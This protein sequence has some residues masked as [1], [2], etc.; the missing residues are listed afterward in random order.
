MPSVEAPQRQTGCDHQRGGILGQRM[1]VHLR[2]QGHLRQRVGDHGRHAQLFLDHFR[3]AAEHGAAAGQHDVVNAVELAAC[4]EELQ[5]A[6]DLLDR[7]FLE[8]L[9][10]FHLVAFR[11]PALALGQAGLLVAQA[12]TAH[13]LVGQLLATEH[14]FAAVQAAAAAQDIE[15][16]HGGADVHERDH[17]V[18]GHRQLAGDQGVGVLD[19]EGLHVHHL[20]LQ[21]TQFQGRLAQFHV[22]RTRRGQQYLDHLRVVRDRPDH[23]EVQ[24]HFL[25]RVRNVV[26][27]FQLDLGFHV[28]LVELGRHR[29]HLGDHRRTGNG[30]SGQLGLAPRAVHRAADG[31]TYGL[32]FHDVL[33]HHR[34]RR[35]RFHSVVFHAK[36][37][38]TAGQLQKLYRSRTDVDAYKRR[39]T[40]WDEPH[41]FSPADGHLDARPAPEH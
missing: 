11:Q 37:V 5:Q 32:H 13:D 40:F 26:D 6:A 36:T 3:Q 25:D 18:D 41:G 29:D 31:L 19:R 12:V 9:Q 8:R 35:K 14:L 23:L 1:C 7:G 15:R 16:G 10:H 28:V 30:G 17:A 22:L 39:L 21:A 33:F 4:I 38:A 2:P 27:R 24:V 34:I 20:G